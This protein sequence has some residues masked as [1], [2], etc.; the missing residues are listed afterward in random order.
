MA[1]G[2]NLAA[3]N[4]AV[5]LATVGVV[6]A[7]EGVALAAGALVTA[8]GPFSPDCDNRRPLARWFRHRGSVHWWGWPVLAAVAMWG[9]GAPVAAYG[10]VLGWWSHI[11]ADALGALGSVAGLGCRCG[12]PVGPGL[13]SDAGGDRPEG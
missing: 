11:V 6:T 2:H 9:V 7:G 13:G 8:A 3:V 4:L 10:P 1:P 12:V 5:G